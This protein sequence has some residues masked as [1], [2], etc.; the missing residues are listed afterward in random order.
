[1]TVPDMVKYTL[2]SDQLFGIDGYNLPRE[3][4]PR[5]KG[6]IN[7]FPKNKGKNFAE[8]EAALTKDVPGP[9][10][11]NIQPK[12]GLNEKKVHATKKN[13]FLDQIERVEKEKPSAA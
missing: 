13:T 6:I 4:Y 7:A 3:E 11:Y 8:I 2:R 12:W 9:G 10:K 1:M 5:Y